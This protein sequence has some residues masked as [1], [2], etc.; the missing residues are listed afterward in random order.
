MMLIIARF[1]ITEKLSRERER[2][3]QNEMLKCVDIGGG[4]VKNEEDGQ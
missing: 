2:E 3:E 4:R 1:V